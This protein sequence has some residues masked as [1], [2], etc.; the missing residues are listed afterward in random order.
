MVKPASKL[1]GKANK[2]NS[3]KVADYAYGE[4]DL[5]LSKQP[6][7]QYIIRILGIRTP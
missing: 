3:E 1:L 4:L 7:T 6:Y 5:N 2:E